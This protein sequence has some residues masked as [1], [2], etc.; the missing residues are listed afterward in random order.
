MSNTALVQI[1]QFLVLLFFIWVVVAACG[2]RIHLPKT[3]FEPLIDI[4]LVLVLLIYA[5]SLKIIFST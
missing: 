5:V 1:I 2:A 4:W 3:K